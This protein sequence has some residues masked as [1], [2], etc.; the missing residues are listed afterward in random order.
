MS[1]ADLRARVSLLEAELQ[2]ERSLRRPV[3][4]EEVIRLR[5]ELGLLQQLVHA[6]R[7]KAALYAALLR[8]L[9]DDGV[10]IARVRRRLQKALH[11]DR[12]K[13]YKSVEGLMTT[14]SALVNEEL[15]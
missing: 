5:R 12:Q 10:R 15:S 7:R 6:D 11:P 13:R 2:R 9:S 14:L 8:E 4:P 1:H 3:G